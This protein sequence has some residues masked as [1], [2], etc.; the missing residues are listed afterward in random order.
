MCSTLNG[1]TPLYITNTYDNANNIYYVPLSTGS[2]MYTGGEETGYAIV[3]RSS[4]N[5]M[6]YI[7]SS[8]VYNIPAGETTYVHSAERNA[9]PDSGTVDGLTYSYLGIPFEKTVTA[10]RVATGSYVGTGTY[11]SSNKTSITFDFVPKVVFISPKD[12][13]TYN[14]FPYIVGNTRF[15]LQ[16]GSTTVSNAVTWSG[17]KMSW[18]TI[19]SGASA[20][21]QCNTSGTTYYYVAIG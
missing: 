20:E 11:G 21:S 5:P 17:T 10:P 1:M 2:F 7:V 9:Y 12:T 16:Q 4:S 19:S 3:F 13:H 18:Y 8:Q 14:A 6:P 15:Y